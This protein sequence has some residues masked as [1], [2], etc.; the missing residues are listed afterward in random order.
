ML[1]NEPR[2]NQREELVCAQRKKEFNVGVIAR[3]GIYMYFPFVWDPLDTRR[4]RQ[5]GK[6]KS[7]TDKEE[8]K[9][10]GGG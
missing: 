3:P 9:G 4:P 5:G 1:A 7:T 6:R 10:K 8:D 2:G